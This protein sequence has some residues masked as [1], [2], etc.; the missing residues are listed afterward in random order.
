[1]VVGN[2]HKLYKIR[3]NILNSALETLSTKMP[4]VMTNILMHFMQT[5]FYAEWLS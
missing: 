2:N 5:R 4:I 3:N 1:M